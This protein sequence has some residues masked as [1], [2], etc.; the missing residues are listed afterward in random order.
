MHAWLLA[1]VTLVKEMGPT[2]GGTQQ[3]SGIGGEFLGWELARRREDK[4]G[5]VAAMRAGYCEREKG[6]KTR[7]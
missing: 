2:P 6:G 1:F 5:G 3:A 7:F 4:I